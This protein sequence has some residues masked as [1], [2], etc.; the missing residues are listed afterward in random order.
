LASARFW[1][2]PDIYMRRIKH[3]HLT[4]LCDHS[5][6]GPTLAVQRTH[7]TLRGLQ[8]DWRTTNFSLKKEKMLE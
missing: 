8:K 3:A 2:L 5:S 6:N 7:K 4:D 1:L